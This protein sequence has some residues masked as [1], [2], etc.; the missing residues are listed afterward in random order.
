[1]KK[2]NGLQQTNGS[3]GHLSKDTAPSEG[4]AS[5]NEKNSLR[6][7]ASNAINS[8]RSS[9]SNKPSVQYD[10]SNF[11]KNDTQNENGIRFLA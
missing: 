9:S 8:I 7:K 5:Q 4:L 11:Y 6:N 2:I 3:L 1:L 10:F